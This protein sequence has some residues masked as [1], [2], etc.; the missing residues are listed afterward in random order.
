[1]T[2]ENNPYTH[3]MP[4]SELMRNIMKDEIKCIH[5]G[6]EDILRHPDK[7]TALEQERQL[8]NELSRLYKKYYDVTGEKCGSFCDGNYE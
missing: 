2:D 4:F 8:R 5:M 3:G 6:L 1:M 7:P